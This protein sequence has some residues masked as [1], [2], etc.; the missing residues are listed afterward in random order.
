MEKVDL[1]EISCQGWDS[2]VR[3][4]NDIVE[5]AAPLEIGPRITHFGFSGQENEIAIDENQAGMKGGDEWRS[6][7]GHRLW[8]S[9]EDESRTYVPD[10]SP[11][12]MEKL[13][14]G[15]RLVQPIE[16]FTMICKEIEVTMSP[17]EPKVQVLHRLT[18]EGAWDIELS[19]WAL[20]VM[21]PGG[22]AIIPLSRGDPNE[23][24]P[25]RSITLWPYS[26][27]D[28]E[29]L[30]L[31]EGYILI[32]QDPD[33]DL[34]F[35]IGA[36]VKDGWTAYANNGHLF[37]KHFSYE[38]Q[39][40]PDFQS[41]VEIYTNDEMLELETLGPMV[42]LGSGE[43]VEH[44]ETWELLSDVSEPKDCEDVKNEILPEINFGP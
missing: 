42:R 31:T 44:L 4:S 41:S 30:D 40:Y 24:L 14:G 35:K 18:N 15:F 36:S 37:V 7:G 8:H 3:L 19:V 43:S 29:R 21:A 38:E 25:D 26:K 1:E 5:L 20:S 10:N 17:T 2:C 34:P 22:R 9:P 39:K 27:L 33:S 28:D 16:E 11:V 23:L 12:E 13:E 6:Y 32:D